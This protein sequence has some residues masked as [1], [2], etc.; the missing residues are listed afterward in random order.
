MAKT[1]GSYARQF[2]F[3]VPVTP[4]DSDDLPFGLTRGIMVGTDGTVA[5]TYANGMT[6]TLTLLAGIPHAISVLRVRTG[7]TATLIKAGY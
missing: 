2:A 3:T 5:V 7:G 1:N 6:D 4:S